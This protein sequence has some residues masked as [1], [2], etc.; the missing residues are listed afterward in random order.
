MDLLPT[1][2]LGLLNAWL[3]I[4]PLLLPVACVAA[5][6]QEVASRMSDMT[7]GCS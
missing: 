3:L 4:L 5:T 2:R 1:F 6:K 7:G